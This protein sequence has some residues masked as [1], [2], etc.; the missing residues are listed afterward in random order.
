MR[1]TADKGA[2][3]RWPLA[4]GRA[5]A[6]GVALALIGCAPAATGAPA[7]G[8]AAAQSADPPLAWLLGDEV[9]VLPLQ[10]IEIRAGSTAPAPDT[11]GI[12]RAFDAGLQQA[13]GPYVPAGRWV[14]PPALVTLRQRNPTVMPDP[15]RLT[16]RGLRPNAAADTQLSQDLG[17]QIRSIL[18]LS[19]ARRYVLLPLRLT[20]TP[21]PAGGYRSELHL[22]VLDSRRAIVRQ[23]FSH[24][25]PRA[26]TAEA[27]AAAAVA[28]AAAGLVTP[29]S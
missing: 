6:T 8:A 18:A 11:A 4:A 19:G 16:V 25:G 24:S 9:L 20:L 29:D 12:R 22:L 5:V 27:A 28:G 3:G 15:S 23:P 17:S 14:W 21:D 13:V 10:E 7:A 1:R 26:D 2:I